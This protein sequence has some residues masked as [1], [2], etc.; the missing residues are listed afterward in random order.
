MKIDRMTC[1]KDTICMGKLWRSTFVFLVLI[2]TSFPSYGQYKSE[3]DSLLTIRS[4][5]VLPVSDNLDGIYSRPLEQHILEVLGADHKFESRSAN[6]SGPILTPEELEDSYSQSQQ[7]A[8]SLSTDSYLATRISKGPRG[9]AVKMTLFLTKDARVLVKQ[10]LNDFKL[11]DIASLKQQ[12]GQLVRKV[13]S[14]LPY[15]G[16]VLS[17][18]GTRVTVNLGTKDGVIKDQV[19]SVVQIIKA[20]RHPRFN[21][22]VSTEKEI[23]GKVRLLK[24]EDTLS[25]GRIVTEKE[26]NAVQVF[27]KISG[28]DS[29][30]YA[31]SGQLSDGEINEGSLKE[32]PESPVTFGQ[33]P[34]EWLPTRKPTFGQVG[35]RVG[36][37][38]YSEKV[39]RTSDSLEVDAPFYPFI[40]I[41]GEVWLTPIWSMHAGIRQGIITTDNPVSGG[42]PSELSH[43]VS[44]YDFLV[45]YNL[46]LGPNMDSPKV[47]VMGGFSNYEMYVDASNPVGLTTK[48]YNGM[49]FGLSGNYPLKEGSPFQVGAQMFFFFD[50]D[51]NEDPGVSG[52]SDNTITQ[53]GA[54]VD[55]NL[56]INLKARFHLDFE[57]YSSNFSGGTAT[58][59][60]QKHTSLSAGIYYLF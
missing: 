29:V 35:A 58:S 60:S 48:N 13:L 22:L 52:K 50:A 38:S 7:L 8:A 53:F 49:K 16:M 43:R 24:V 55:K 26:T 46:R 12:V 19:V 39:A 18:E 45:G 32:R 30:V 4:I 40:G 54:Y 56:K 20:T 51:L 17:R 42:S 2:L 47:E 11:A 25:F 59:G 57:L 36:L 44:S 34:T 14:A 33:N 1:F 15:D 27:S 10:E 23:L 6:I 37:G 3:I 31:D 21:F 5:T 9:I 28:L 41:D